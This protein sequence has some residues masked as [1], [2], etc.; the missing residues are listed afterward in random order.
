MGVRTTLEVTCDFT[1]CEPRKV[2]QWVTE[3][4]NSGK[5]EIPEAAKSF[6]SLNLNG[7]LLSFCGR[8]HAASFFLPAGYDIVPKKVGDI[9]V[10]KPQQIEVKR[11]W[12]D[13]PRRSEG[14]PVTQADGF[15]PDNGHEEGV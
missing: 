14:D 15:S 5:A 12:K 6:I 11:D 1:G 3:D 8:L 9:T 13:L 10:D 7:N 4:I 2:V